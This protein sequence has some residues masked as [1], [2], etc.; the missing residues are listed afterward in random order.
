MTKQILKKAYDDYGRFRIP[1]IVCLDSGKLLV[2]YECRKDQYAK[3]GMESD[4]A[5]SDVGMKS[6]V[7]GGK[8]WSPD[9]ILARGNGENTNNP[10][11][12]ADGKTVVF[13][14]HIAYFRTFCRRSLD[15]GETW[16]EPVEITD[17]LR[18]PDRK[19]TVAACGPGHGTVLADGR[20]VVPIWI[21]SNPEDPKAHHPAVLS[22]LYSDDRGLSWKL[23]DI[24]DKDYMGNPTETCL[25]QLADGTVMINIRQHSVR[26][27][28]MIAYSAGGISK[29]H[30]FHLE[31]ALP[32]P[33]CMAGMVAHDG[34]VYFVNC[35]SETQRRELT[36]FE[37]VDGAMWKPLAV[38]SEPAGYA[39]VAVSP[40]G[41]RL[42]VFYEEF[43]PEEKYLT[44][45]VLDLPCEPEESTS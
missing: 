4:W 13:I 8:T 44:F 36:V 7:D 31:E 30:G 41:T 15:E 24:I 9:V 11:M 25:A 19:W 37:T 34:K 40:D 3:T 27:R 1:G 10:V 5:P 2:Y 38:V 17:V 21:V 28:R 20:Y 32:D 33:V 35:H 39:D 23:G 29:W 12:F 6:S 22:M 14:Y 18:V 16:D 42:Y 26:P 43:T 45:A